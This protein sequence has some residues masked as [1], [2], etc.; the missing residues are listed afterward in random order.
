MDLI[1]WVDDTNE[2]AQLQLCYDKGRRRAERA[3]TWKPGTGFT[4]TAVD[5]GEYGNGRYKATP[6]MVVDGGFNTERVDGLF[7]NHSVNLPADIVHFVSGK[8]RE[9]QAVSPHAHLPSLSANS[10]IMYYQNSA[11]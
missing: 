2:P 9:Y 4:H 7:H 5:D 11:L 10:S 8:I 6:I 3:F 1:V